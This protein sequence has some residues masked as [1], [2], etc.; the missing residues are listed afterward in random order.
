MLEALQIISGLAFAGLVLNLL[1][2]AIVGAKCPNCAK[3]KTVTA[4]GEERPS[5]PIGFK[6]ETQ[7]ICRACGATG[8]SLRIRWWHLI[9]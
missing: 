5:T 9:P 7:W 2:V 4:T 8:W 1:L 3:R 6:T